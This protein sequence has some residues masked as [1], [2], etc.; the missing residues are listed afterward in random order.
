VAIIATVYAGA[1]TT[2]VGNYLIGAG[3]IK[4]K[5]GA[6]VVS[7]N[8]FNIGSFRDIYPLRA[9]LIYLDTPTSDSQ[10]YSVE[11]TNGSTQAHNCWAE[12]IAFDVTDAAFLDTDSVAVGTSQTTVGNLSTTLSGDVAVIALAAAE[13]TVPTD[14]TISTKMGSYYRE[15]IHQQAK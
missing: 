13:S 8:E 6:T 15:I 1:A 14:G 10:T 4:L 3:N 11:I 9:S 5:S 12:I 2:T 7:S